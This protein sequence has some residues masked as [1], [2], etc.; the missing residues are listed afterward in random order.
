MNSSGRRV[1]YVSC[2]IIYHNFTLYENGFTTRGI[3]TPIIKG[4]PPAED[5]RRELANTVFALIDS[6]SFQSTMRVIPDDEKPRGCGGTP[7][8]WL[9]LDGETITAEGSAEVL[10]LLQ[11]AYMEK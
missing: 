2:G 4:M 11:N 7:G 1:S 5:Y 8:T 9:L 6:P 3:G 10:G